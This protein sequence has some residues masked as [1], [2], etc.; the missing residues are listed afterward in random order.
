MATDP[1]Q[2]GMPRRS[3]LNAGLAERGPDDERD[4]SQ[5]VFHNATGD[6]EEYWG[7]KLGAEEAF[8]KA[9]DEAFMKHAIESVAPIFNGYLS[10][11][12][13]LVRELCD[14]RRVDGA[15]VRVLLRSGQ[16]L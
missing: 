9:E 8:S 13:R 15:R 14:A 7:R 11:M 6:R 4:L 1:V 10:G 2:D 12:Q 16:R 5:I 3:L